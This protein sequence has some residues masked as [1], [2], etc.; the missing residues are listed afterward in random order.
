M[1]PRIGVYESTGGGAK[2]ARHVP[3]YHMVLVTDEEMKLV[4]IRQPV[5]YGKM[6]DADS[7]VTCE[8]CKAKGWAQTLGDLRYEGDRADS[9][10]AQDRQNAWRAGR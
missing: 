6:V 7:K 10:K 5:K 1:I 8:S 3:V 2:K 4:C 9:I